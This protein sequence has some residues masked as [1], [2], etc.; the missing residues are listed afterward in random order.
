MNKGCGH[1]VSVVTQTYVYIRVHGGFAL[2]L[3]FVVLFY[4]KKNVDHTDH[5]TTLDRNP[6]G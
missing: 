3:F 4:F 6:H 5:L 2:D 1:V